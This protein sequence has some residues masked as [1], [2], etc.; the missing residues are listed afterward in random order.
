MIFRIRFLTYPMKH[1][2]S[3][4][5][6]NIY[7]TTSSSLC[8]IV[9]N[10]DT[11]QYNAVP[12]QQK[13]LTASKQPWNLT[14]F[15]IITI[16]N[17]IIVSVDY[18]VLFRIIK[19]WSLHNAIQEIWLAQWPWYM[20]HYTMP[21]K[22]GKR[23]REFMGAFLFPFQSNFPRFCGVFNKTIIPLALVGYEM[24]M[25]NSALRASL[26]IYHLISN[27]GSWNNC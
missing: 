9:I 26:A 19:N 10:H 27:A 22:Y 20:S 6:H 8:D 12:F 24:I 18:S 11:I 16:H 14:E 7:V 4:Y 1:I 15:D 25:A 13:K 3:R 23:T 21:Y 17:T 2:L 5:Y